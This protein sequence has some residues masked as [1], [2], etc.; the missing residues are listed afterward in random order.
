[1]YCR[2]WEHLNRVSNADKLNISVT[3]L[4]FISFNIESKKVVTILSSSLL[5][6]VGKD[7]FTIRR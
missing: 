2:D 1:M 3:I 5:I 7:E 6:F 4:I